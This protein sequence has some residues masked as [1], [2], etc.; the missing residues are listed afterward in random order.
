M[1][2]EHVERLKTIREQFDGSKFALG[3]VIDN[4]SGLGVD[5]KASKIGLSKVQTANDELETT[6]L[7]RLFSE[8]ESILRDYCS[9]VLKITLRAQTS[10]M[11]IINRVSSRLKIEP[12]IVFDVHNVREQRNRAVHRNGY[13]AIALAFADALAAM[14]KFLVRL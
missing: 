4:W 9:S 5:A 2:Y 14:N 8:F 13:G 7:I 6:Y 12:A 3:Y 11:T 10:V 1:S